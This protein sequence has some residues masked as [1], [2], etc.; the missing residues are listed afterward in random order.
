MLL[1]K[2]ADDKVV[3]KVNSF[4]VHAGKEWTELTNY[5]GALVRDHVSIVHDEWRHVKVKLKDEMWNHLKELFVL[6]DNSKKHEDEP[7]KLELPPAEYKH[8]SKKE[9]KLFVKKTFSEEFVQK[10]LGVKNLEDID[11]CDTWLLGRKKKMGPMM[12]MSKKWQMK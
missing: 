2:A 10:E 3:V 7:V 4:G 6:S 5:I 9:W 8:I 12:M 11:R 1:K